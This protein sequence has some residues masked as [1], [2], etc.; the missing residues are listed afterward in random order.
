LGNNYPIT[1]IPLQENKSQAQEN[2]KL[3]KKLLKIQN[4]LFEK[5]ENLGNWGN[6]SPTSFVFEIDIF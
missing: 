3:L 4:P 1:Q 5:L 6:Y 2:F